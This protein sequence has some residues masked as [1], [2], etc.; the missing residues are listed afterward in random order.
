[1]SVVK[2]SELRSGTRIGKFPVEY[3]AQNN[4]RLTTVDLKGMAEQPS[5]IRGKAQGR[6]LECNRMRRVV[7]VDW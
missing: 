6:A 7:L 2:S 3:S 4:L 5:I 1:M